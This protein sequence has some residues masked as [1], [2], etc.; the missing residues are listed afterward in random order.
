MPAALHLFHQPPPLH[1][2]T[3][4][5][6]SHM[7]AEGRIN[8]RARLEADSNFWDYLA[9]RQ[10][11]VVRAER[12]AEEMRRDGGRKRDWQLHGGI[13]HGAQGYLEPGAG[14]GGLPPPPFFRY[15]DDRSLSAPFPWDIN[16]IF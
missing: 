9:E 11:A 8:A 7:Q 16:H 14:S 6:F 3:L 12:D 2:H 4:S 15:V 10:A 5:S 1:Q 13:G